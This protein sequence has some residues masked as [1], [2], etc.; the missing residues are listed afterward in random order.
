MGVSMPPYYLPTPSVRN[1]NNYFPQAEPL[2]ADEMRI[3]FMG[4][5]PW[6]P[7][8]TQAAT[9][10]MV[11]L[12]NGT[13]LF[14]D[15]GPGCLRNIIASQVPVPEI[16]DIFLTHLH[17]DHM[18]EIPYLWQFAPFNGRWKPLRVYGP[19][20]SRPELGTRAMVEHLKA[21]GLWTSIQAKGMPLEGGYEIDVTEF[22]FRDDG[23]VVYDQDGVR[24]THWRRSHAVDGASAYR[25]DWNGLSFVW[26]GDGK[27]DW[28]TAE[29]AKGVDVFVTE[30]AVD[31]VQLWALKQGVHPF[32]GAWT[33][34][35]Y[36]TT[37][38][39]AG[40]LANL[41]QPRLAM[42][43]HVS[44]D[45][46]LI[47]ELMSGIRMHYAGLFAFGIDRTVVNVTK[48]RVWI[49]EASLPETSNTLRGD[50]EWLFQ[51]ELDGKL[52]EPRNVENPLLKVQE[53]F[54]RDQEIPPEL[55][56]PKDQV[57]PWARMGPQ[58]PMNPANVMLGPGYGD[59]S[60]AHPA[61]AGPAA[62][63]PTGAA[64]T[65]T[66]PTRPD[67]GDAHG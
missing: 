41:V 39:A 61:A 47:G 26:T 65:G 19:S 52:P 8:M 60:P 54:V 30:M 11:E 37:H 40:Y 10:I 21:M 24:V 28:L 55:F 38:Y 45:R 17:I 59:P 29:Y 4:S 42:A 36:H 66:A 5:S 56:T 14:F 16:N 50:P 27:P 12:G 64:P 46:E 34:D 7:R 67:A 58:I 53:Q 22:D 1:K 20:S 15:F 9:C 25:L 18:G 44:F 6:P 57:R 35:N 23:G 63:G 51:H 2:G 13:R 62:G 48:E 33:L 49:R 43:T 32:I 3:S 31:M